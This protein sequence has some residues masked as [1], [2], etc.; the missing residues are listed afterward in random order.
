MFCKKVFLEISQN[1][2]EISCARVSFLIK[3]Q[4]R[5]FCHG[6]FPVNFAKFLRTTFAAEDLQRL[7]LIQR[8]TDHVALLKQGRNNIN[9]FMTETVTI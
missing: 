3:L 6:C 9:S 2:Q 4:E 1:S 7:L 5:R 8:C